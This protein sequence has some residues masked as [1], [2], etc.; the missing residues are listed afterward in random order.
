MSKESELPL[1]VH[2]NYRTRRTRKWPT[3][4]AIVIGAYQLW[5]LWARWATSASWLPALLATAS[6]TDAV[7]PQVPEY[8]AKAALGELKIE[9]PTIREAVDR[10][11]QA[12]QIDTAVQDNWVDP[13]EDPEPWAKFEAFAN[14]L[15]KAFPAVHAYESPLKRE[16]LHKHGLLYIWPGS[17]TSLKPLLLTAHQDVVPI[18]QTTQHDW[19]FPPFSGYIDLVNQ[20][21]WG[22]GAFDC[23]VRLLGTLSAAESL[24]RSNWTPRRTIVLAYGYDE[25]VGGEQGAQYLGERLQELYGND[26]IAMLVDEGMPV[27]SAYDVESFGAPI[28]A[29]AVSEKGALNVRVEV[30]SKGGHSSMPP[31]HTSI[32][33]LSKIVTFLEDHPFPDKIKE[34][35]EAQIRFLQCLRDHPRVPKKLRH[36]LLEL[37]YAE[38]SLDAGFLRLY[39]AELPVYERLYLA[40]APITVQQ[41]RL[42]RA[43]K[44]VLELLN[45]NTRLVLKTTQAVDVIEGGVKVNA[46][47]ESAH[48]IVNH[49]IAPYSSVAETQ[50]RYKKLLTS[51]ARTLDLSFTAFGEELVPHTNASAGALVVTNESWMRDVAHISPFEG[52]NAGPFRLLSS[53]IRQTWHLDEPRHVLHEGANAAPTSKKPFK[54]SVRVTPSTMFANTDT[55][56]YR[57]LT[58]NVFRFGPAT[59]HR[60]LTGIPMLHTTHTVNEH[61]PIDAIMKAIEFY[62]NLMVAVDFEDLEKV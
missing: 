21:V 10:L 18:D 27:Y 3:I 59:L 56:W 19:L 35:S 42:E 29:P 51:V 58:Q 2:P 41:N 31:P 53:V 44:R 16:F 12:V 62:T 55:F 46:L 54:D 50:D 43:R 47:P 7:C 24:L 32:G 4:L 48:A 40:A 23:K 14:Y 5:L 13:N 6:D 11:S 28:A 52:K 33:L 22:R 26:G 37:E 15:E 20:T 39:A 57:N 36:A 38:R 30:R 61:V 45:D 1:V 25:E 34:K 9:L 8:D 17:D 49:R 60:D